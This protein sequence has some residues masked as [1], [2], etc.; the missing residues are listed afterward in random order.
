MPDPAISVCIPVRNGAEWIDE[1]IA[2][3]HI[4]LDDPDDLESAEW[5]RRYGMLHD[6][7]TALDEVCSPS[8]PSARTTD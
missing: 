6:R 3:R 5:A 2:R 1:A 8:R 7:F 4:L